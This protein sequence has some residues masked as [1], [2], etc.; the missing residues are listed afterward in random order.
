MIVQAGAFAEH[1]ITAV[2]LHRLR[3]TTP[4]SVTC[5]TT[6]T[7]EPAVTET[8]Q[9]CDS[10]FLT[11]RLPASTRIRLTLRLEP[12]HQRPQLP[13]PVRHPSLGSRRLNA[14]PTARTST[15]NS[16]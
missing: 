1:T 7:R 12:A 9:A 3:A 13:H 5:T 11:V 6:G 16:R 4:G 10:A 15:R 14:C 8:E 2:R